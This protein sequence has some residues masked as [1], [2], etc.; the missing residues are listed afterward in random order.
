MVAYVVVDVEVNDDERYAGYLEAANG[1]HAPFGGR[2]LARGTSVH[3]LEGDWSPKRFV[4]IE[5]PDRKA[6]RD[7]YESDGCQAA[8]RRRLGAATFRA[9]IVD[10]IP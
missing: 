7:W 1:T 4:I 9:V 5:F 8:R 10:G 6:A 2:F 3:G